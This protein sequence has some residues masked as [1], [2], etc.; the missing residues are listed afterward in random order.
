MD[1]NKKVY[2]S[3]I[4]N[5]IKK[6][7]IWEGIKYFY[8]EQKKIIIERI[9]QS[10]KKRNVQAEIKINNRTRRLGNYDRPDKSWI[11]EGKDKP[12]THAQRVKVRTALDKAMKKLDD[13]MRDLDLQFDDI[14]DT[15]KR[16]IKK[17]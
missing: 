5:W 4:L 2:P 12:L 13:N 3:D 7:R 9:D 16:Y 10:L 8:G 14:W 15:R 17:R 1:W 6:W 11:W